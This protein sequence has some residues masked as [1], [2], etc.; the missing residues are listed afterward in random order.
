MNGLT[1][2]RCSYFVAFLA[3]L[4]PLDR[5]QAQTASNAPPRGI[6]ASGEVHDNVY[7]NEAIGLQF[8]VPSALKFKSP[9]LKGKPETVLTIAAVWREP[10][11]R[12]GAAFYAEDLGYHGADRSTEAYVKR[13]V[14]AQRKLGFDRVEAKGYAQLDERVRFAR[15]DFQQPHLY[16][17]VFV[18]A[19][20]V[21]AFVFVFDAADLE[22]TNNLIAQTNVKLDAKHSGCR[23][24]K[25]ASSPG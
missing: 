6:L 10:S 23:A 1:L 9:S 20:D 17:A 3:C 22:S 7:T 12:G 8:S 19:C 14:N 4:C 15:V 11:A 21:Y 24:A 13:L 18:K 2:V 25:S 5:G 16:E